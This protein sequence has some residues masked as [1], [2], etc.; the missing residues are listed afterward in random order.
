[1]LCTELPQTPRPQHKQRAS[2]AEQKREF[3]KNLSRREQVRRENPQAEVRL[4]L[5]MKL[6]SIAAGIKNDGRKGSSG[7]RD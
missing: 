1:M 5:R 2:E 3:K 7:S 4:E 6:D